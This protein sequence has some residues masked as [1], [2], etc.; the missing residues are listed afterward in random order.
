MIPVRHAH[1][2]LFGK[3]V[4]Y[5]IEESI[6]QD[7]PVLYGSELPVLSSNSTLW[8]AVSR[9]IFE[10]I[11]HINQRFQW[12]SLIVSVFFLWLPLTRAHCLI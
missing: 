4:V 5:I 6:H 9:G 11:S 3:Y 8:H 12:L 2:L 7:A 10:G 1:L